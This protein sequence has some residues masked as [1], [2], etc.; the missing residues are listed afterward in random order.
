V[1]FTFGLPAAADIARLQRLGSEAWVTVTSAADATA[2]DAAGADGLVVQGSEAGGHRGG[3]TDTEGIGLL[4]LLQLVRAA[5]SLPLIA[6]GGV[7]TSTG[8]AA[9]LRAG[10]QAAALGTAFLLCPE[11]GTAEVHREA[12]RRAD[13]PTAL[14]RAFTGRLARGIRNRF[15]D[16]Y[17]DAAPAA[18]PEVHHLTAPLRAHGRSNGDGE[19]VNLWAGE[20]YPLAM[21]LPAAEI[22]KRVAPG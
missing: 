16:A 18:Y 20:A 22:V 7:M 4:A 8:L 10:A 13:R 21:E 12:V 15:L 3:L 11:A 6:G 19:V 5:S 1:S 17:S 9:V 14:T 2:A